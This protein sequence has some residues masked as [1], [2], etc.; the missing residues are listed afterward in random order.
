MAKRD[1]LGVWFEGTLVAEL[2]PRRPWDLRCAY[3][4]EALARWPGQI[5]LLSCSLPLQ[6]RLADAS[7]F[8][9][10]LLPEGQ[11]RL[12]LAAELKVAAHDTH[13]LLSR[14]GRDVAGA[15]VIS[16]TEPDERSGEIG[17][18]HV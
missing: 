7:V 17:R 11:H 9:S 2:Q 1:P 4:P 14:F 5:P 10:G 13:A 15:L 3:S 12:A 6:P 18:A 16:A 8:A